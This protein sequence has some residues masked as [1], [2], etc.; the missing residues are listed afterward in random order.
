MVGVHELKEQARF[1]YARLPYDRD[2]LALSRTRLSERALHLRN[3]VLPA[4]EMGQSARLRGM[5]AT[6]QLGGASELVD[7]YRIRHALDRHRPE[8]LH[9][10]VAFCKPQR[11]RS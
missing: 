11:V 6:M 5:Q 4:D 1:A 3:F 10:H 2:D 7:L 8:R 9:G